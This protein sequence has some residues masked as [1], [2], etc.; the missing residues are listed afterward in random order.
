MR[1]RPAGR[2]A[3]SARSGAR[4]I[5]GDSPK[6]P[7]ASI[8]RQIATEQKLSAE[9]LDLDFEGAR[10]TIFPKFYCT[11]SSKEQSPC[12]SMQIGSVR[13]WRRIG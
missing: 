7:P 8:V 5:N 4:A 2:V 12:T 3:T 10:Q 6:G 13:D 11:T 1:T 9:I